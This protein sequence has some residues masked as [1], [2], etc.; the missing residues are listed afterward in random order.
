MWV[1]KRWEIY[2]KASDV[3]D[4]RN[5]F[6]HFQCVSIVFNVFGN[7]ASPQG[8]GDIDFGSNSEDV[9]GIVADQAERTADGNSD[10]LTNI[11]GSKGDKLSMYKKYR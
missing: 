11:T 3:E 7:F 1:Q 8:G 10:N 2:F 5:Y 6:Q 9:D 4:K